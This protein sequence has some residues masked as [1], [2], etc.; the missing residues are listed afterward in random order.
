M[1]PRC[2]ESHSDREEI[3]GRLKSN[4]GCSYDW[5]A[6]VTECP[7]STKKATDRQKRQQIAQFRWRH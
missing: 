4:Y 3:A 5:P 6:D 1:L 2:S 7:G